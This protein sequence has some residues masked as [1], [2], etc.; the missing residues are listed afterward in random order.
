MPDGAVREFE[1]CD[2]AASLTDEYAPQTDTDV[3]HTAYSALDYESGDLSHVNVYSLNDQSY[4]T[5]ALRLVPRAVGYSGG[6]LDHFFRARLTAD[7]NRNADGSYNVLLTNRTPEPLT[8]AGG[9][10]FYMPDPSTALLVRLVAISGVNIA[11]NGSVTVHVP[12]PGG[13]LGAYERRVV[14]RGQLGEETGAVIGSVSKPDASSVASC[15]AFPDC[16]PTGVGCGV[17]GD[18]RFEISNSGG[19][20]LALEVTQDQSLNVSSYGF[21][22]TC[23]ESCRAT[24]DP[25]TGHAT[26]ANAEVR[27]ADYAGGPESITFH[28]PAEGH[29]YDAIFSSI[30]QGAVDVT[31]R[32][33][34]NNILEREMTQ[35]FESDPRFRYQIFKLP[36]FGMPTPP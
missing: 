10:L 35:T 33:Y 6:V 27:F 14:L 31:F 32:I 18:I 24:G 21:M 19:E 1:E 3:Y 8:D 17:A 2:F 7:W 34:V 9:E 11:A 23:F 12:N 28:V 29:T 13:C 36:H 25:N 26:V 16:S 15:R 30:Y 20:D 22:V 4:V 5:R